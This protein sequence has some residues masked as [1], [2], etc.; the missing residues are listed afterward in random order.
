MRSGSRLAHLKDKQT[1]WSIYKG[2]KE[3]SKEVEDKKE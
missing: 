3:T 2:W 1:K